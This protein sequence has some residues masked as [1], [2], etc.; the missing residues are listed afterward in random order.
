M[1]QM[2][3]EVSTGKARVCQWGN[4]SNP[5]I[6]CFH[7]MGSTNLSFIEIAAKLKDRYHILSVDLPGHGQSQGF[8]KD[9]DIFDDKLSFLESEKVVYSRWSELLEASVYDLM[10]EEDGK[11]KWHATGDTARGIIK[12]LHNQHEKM[13]LGN[14]ESEILL[15]YPDCSEDQYKLNVQMLEMFEKKIKVTTKLYKG[16]THLIHSDRP[17]EVVED[18]LGW[19]GDTGV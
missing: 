9:E 13:K 5:D 3:V 7:G 15:L 1:K 2:F 10:R 16:A 14:I 17:D 19:F 8:E 11:I 18:I 6:I 4:K 12:Y